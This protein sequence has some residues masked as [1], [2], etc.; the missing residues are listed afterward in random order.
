[1]AYLALG[2]GEERVICPVM[3]ARRSQL[4]NALFEIQN[5]K[6]VR[7]RADRA[8]AAQELA[9]ELAAMHRS[10][11]LLGDGWRIGEEALRSRGV[12]YTLAPELNR[13]QNA[14][15]VALAAMDKT[16]VGAE[17]L[18]PVYLRLSQAERERQ[19][20]MK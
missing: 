11:W 20:R 6:P 2:A 7:M 8:V 5:G 17:D 9:E 4:Y 10:V 12:D 16:P 14:A 18:L 3:D 13:Y 15:G 19:E 1:M